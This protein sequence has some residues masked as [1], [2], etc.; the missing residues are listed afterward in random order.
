MRIESGETRLRLLALGHCASMIRSPSALNTS[1]VGDAAD[2]FARGPCQGPR[3]NGLQLTPRNARDQRHGPR[4]RNYAVNQETVT[5]ILRSR[6]SN[7]G[8]LLGWSKLWI[9]VFRSPPRFVVAAA[10]VCG[11]LLLWFY[12]SILLRLLW[13]FGNDILKYDINKI[14]KSIVYL[15]SILAAPAALWAV[16][17]GIQRLLISR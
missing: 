9:A 2:H 10:N 15:G 14:D 7:P 16:F 8:A 17:V 3:F 13:H 4:A 1:D 11:F 6:I 12:I 5:M